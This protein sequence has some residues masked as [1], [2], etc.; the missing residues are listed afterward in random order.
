MQM[1]NEQSYEIF[2]IENLINLTK[3]GI[4]C[5]CDADKKTIKFYKE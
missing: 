1:I 3:K 5:E 4:Y 2:E